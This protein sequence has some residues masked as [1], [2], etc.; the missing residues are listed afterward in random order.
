MIDDIFRTGP[1]C[2]SPVPM[3][4]V[5]ISICVCDL[6]S[7][8]Q[9]SAH[10]MPCLPF[11]CFELIFADQAMSLILIKNIIMIIIYISSLN[12]LFNQR[13]INSQSIVGTQWLVCKNLS[14]LDQ[15]STEMSIEC[16]SSIDGDVYVWVLIK[17]PIE[18][19]SRVAIDNQPQML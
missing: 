18:G 13:S 15:L 14:T 9:L 11:G 12:Q 5:V 6:W 1:L 3:R 10:L 19:Q 4:P 17:M 16:C 7:D 2:L 8:H